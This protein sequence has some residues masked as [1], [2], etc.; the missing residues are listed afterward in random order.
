MLTILLNIMGKIAILV[1]LGYF[2]RKK[3]II[4]Q[5][6]QDGLTSFMM[7]VALPA[8]VLTSAN[9]VFSLELSR[10]LLIVVAVAVCY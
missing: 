4:N 10:N 7:K 9:N 3:E 1:A 5:Q 2:L 6:L 8:N